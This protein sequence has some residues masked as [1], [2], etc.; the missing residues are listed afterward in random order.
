MANSNTFTFDNVRKI[1]LENKTLESEEISV[2]L[3]QINKGYRN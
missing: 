3:E 2:H 1:V